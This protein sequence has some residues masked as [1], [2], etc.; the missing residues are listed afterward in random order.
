MLTITYYPV[1]V[2]PTDILIAIAIIVAIGLATSA[3]IRLAL[4]G[5]LELS[6]DLKR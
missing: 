3:I 2:N 1:R 6:D 4:R 5:N